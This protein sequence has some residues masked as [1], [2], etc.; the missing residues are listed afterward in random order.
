MK[1]IMK[2]IMAVVMAFVMVIGVYVANIT[3][4]FLAAPMEEFDGSNFFGVK[5]TD[6]LVQ[7][8]V[9]KTEDLYFYKNA[10]NN[11]L[12]AYDRITYDNQ[13][14]DWFMNMR[15]VY[16]LN[17]NASYPYG[18]TYETVTMLNQAGVFSTQ[19]QEG[20]A[21]LLKNASYYDYWASQGVSHYGCQV[22]CTQLAFWIALGQYSGA[23]ASGWSG[24]T[25][26]YGDSVSGAANMISKLV[27][28]FNNPDE[29]LS[30]AYVTV[31]PDEDNKTNIDGGNQWFD[32]F[33][34]STDC[35]WDITANISFSYDGVNYTAG[36]PG[37]SEAYLVLH[38][39]SGN[40][41]NVIGS[42]V[43][44]QGES[45]VYHMFE[46]WAK[47]TIRVPYT[48]ANRNLTI[49]VD[50]L[51]DGTSFETSEIYYYETMQTADKNG[52]GNYTTRQN[53]LGYSRTELPKAYDN[54]LLAAST[55]N[56]FL[57]INKKDDSNRVISGVEFALYSDAELTNLVTSGT[58]D[59]NG[60]LSFECLWDS[61]YYL[62]E[63]GVG[64]EDYE[65]SVNI[66][67]VNVEFVKGEGIPVTFDAN[68]EKVYVNGT[69]ANVATDTTNGT[70]YKTSLEVINEKTKYAK[71]SVYKYDE[72]TNVPL[73]GVKFGLYSDAECQNQ[74]DS[75]VT[76]VNGNL[77][78]GQ[79][80]KFG[81]YY[82]KEVATLDT[83]KTD[84]T[85]RTISVNENTATFEQSDELYYINSDVPNTPK[86]V[87]IAV[88]K[89]GEV[90]TGYSNGK[91]TYASDYI[92][93]AVIGIYS[94]AACATAPIATVTTVAGE[95]KNY[96]VVAEY[97]FIKGATYYI[98]EITAPEGYVITDEIKSVTIGTA[99]NIDE[100]YLY[101]TSTSLVNTR[102]KYSVSITKLGHKDT[103]LA[104]AEFTL[105][106]G[107][108]IYAYGK[109]EANGDTPLVRTGDVIKVATTSSDGKLNFSACDLPRAEFSIT[110]T[111][112]P[113]GY[114]LA[115]TDDGKDVV[116]N[117]NLITESNKTENKNVE[118]VKVDFLI[119]NKPYPAKIAISKLGET[120]IDYDKSTHSF[121]YE[122][123]YLGGVKFG[124]Y[125]DEA[126]T[127]LVFYLDISLKIGIE[128]IYS[129]KLTHVLIKIHKMM[130]TIR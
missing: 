108:D 121:M 102:E 64:S 82:I 65:D 10:F 83:Y 103:P 8:G 61:T 21:N 122:K 46:G 43:S 73:E 84:N 50:A 18:A 109:S 52:D 119:D 58:T 116:Y 39:G 16:C 27:E 114:Q 129:A 104:G 99:D 113:T 6:F 4:E 26:K 5:E 125:E 28:C 14:S 67:G 29:N 3:M 120:L 117:F 86:D 80:V 110:E 44:G 85:V 20:L 128:I 37:D 17:V 76:D 124:I 53:M 30:E 69:Q 7:N 40:Y 47:V 41:S 130:L 24:N 105:K 94:D 68:A 62:V 32:Y 11:S 88:S 66:S 57:E 126:L 2:R 25:D 98:K 115:K 19:V 107:S 90:L 42:I 93:G 23:Q 123:N 48:L 91:F 12:S 63:T 35:N 97:T 51:C 79:K 31:Y 55:P 100:E 75:G 54:T 111:K 36:L 95:E 112:A 45:F 15:P 56:V 127:K 72:Q 89:I 96:F 1:K 60:Y 106:A 71:I 77:T 118:N 49:K 22:A 38:D 78:F 74:I 81:T 92:G 9:V 33:I 101:F 70:T 59:A 13:S 34:H 87:K